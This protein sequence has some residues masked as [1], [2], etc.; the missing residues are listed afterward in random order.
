[1]RNVSRGFL[2]ERNDAVGDASA[3]ARRIRL[4]KFL[5][6][7][8]IFESVIEKNGSAARRGRDHHARN[9]RRGP[10]GTEQIGFFFFFF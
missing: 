4:T 6:S 9:E 2:D 1:M 5:D 7:W 3:G 8:R 10:R